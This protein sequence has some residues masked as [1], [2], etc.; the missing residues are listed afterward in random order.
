MLHSGYALA[1]IF[2]ARDMPMPSESSHTVVPWSNTSS[3]MEDYRCRRPA[4]QIAPKFVVK[5][6]GLLS[7]TVIIWLNLLHLKTQAQYLSSSVYV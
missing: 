6:K 7:V 5:K 3:Y 2:N 1:Q 4:N